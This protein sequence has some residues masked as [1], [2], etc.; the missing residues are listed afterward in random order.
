MISEVQ[1]LVKVSVLWK[2][3]KHVYFFFYIS[4]LGDQ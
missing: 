3:N 4:D 1:T 2:N